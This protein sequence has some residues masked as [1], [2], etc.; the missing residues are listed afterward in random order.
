M[1]TKFTTTAL[2]YNLGFFLG[3]TSHHRWLRRRI[4]YKGR[5]ISMDDPFDGRG[6]AM[7]LVWTLLGHRHLVPGPSIE[8]ASSPLLI[9][10]APLL[11]E[12]R[13]AGVTTPLTN[14]LTTHASF[15]GLARNPDSP[16]T[17]T[18]SIPR[19]SSADSRSSSG[20][21]DAGT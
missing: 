11:K 7:S 9:H 2:E 18:Q 10:A 16:P 3:L 4:L 20:S 19:K 12:E 14:L 6:R 1:C 21:R 17:I 5:A 15:I 13:Y 8:H